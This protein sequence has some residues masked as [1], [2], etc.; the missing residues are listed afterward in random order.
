MDRRV[1]EVLQYLECHWRRQLSIGDLA[2]SVNLG[3]SRLSHLVKRYAKTSI[4]DLVRRRRI[5][6]AA[7]L[8]LTTHQRISEIGYA[9]GFA[10]MSNFNHAFRRELGISPRAYRERELALR[11]D[12][13]ERGE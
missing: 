5:A 3:P 12:G 7:N 10:D 2:R 1:K 4:R 13:A 9:V 11:D 6:E 8:L